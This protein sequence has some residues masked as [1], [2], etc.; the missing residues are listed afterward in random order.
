VAGIALAMF[1]AMT[2]GLTFATQITLTFD[3][4]AYD[5]TIPDPGGD[6]HG[7]YAWVESNGIR[8]AGF[9]GVDVGT[10]DA[11]FKQGHV[12]IT[13]NYD[14]REDGRPERM[15]SWT[16][17]LQGIY[18]SLENGYTFDVISI[19]YSIFNRD[20]T[21]PL[22]QRLGWATGPE[23]AQLLLSTSFDPTASDLES[24]WTKFA[25]DDDGRPY[26][27]WFTR[28]IDGFDNLT[29]FYLSQTLFQLEVD[30]IVLNVHEPAVVPEPTSALL[31]GMGF[32]A[33]ALRKRQ[34]ITD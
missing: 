5:E 21:D 29:G 3:D 13:P 33:L 20:T 11:Y 8:S 16:N 6:Q 10:P 17:D 27:P 19:D 34:A 2:P 23:D 28:Q 14:G 31:L 32:A 22:A 15:H 9:W 12:H 7:P 18:I 24:Q 25:V 30:S 26:R 4:G 1:L